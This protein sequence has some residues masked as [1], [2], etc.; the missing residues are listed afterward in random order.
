MDRHLAD[1]MLLP[2]A[3][4]GGPSAFTCEAATRHLTTNAWVIEQFGAAQVLI[5]EQRDS[6][7]RVTVRPHVNCR[8]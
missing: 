6:S 5:E 7:A 1:Q 2:L 3:L 4:A 8:S